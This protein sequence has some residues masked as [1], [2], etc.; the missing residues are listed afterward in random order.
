MSEIAVILG[1]LGALL[2]GA[3]SPGPSFIVVSRIGMTSSRRNGIAAA[4]GM[5]L[6]GSDNAGFRLW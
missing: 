1:I 6:G 2:I 4:L 3:M 5:G